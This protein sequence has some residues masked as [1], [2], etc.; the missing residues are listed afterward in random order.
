VSD[1]FIQQAVVTRRYLRVKKLLT[2][3]GRCVMLC[4]CSVDGTQH[5]APAERQGRT[6]ALPRSLPAGKRRPPR[7]TVAGDS[8]P[9]DI[10][11]F[12]LLNSKAPQMLNFPS[13]SRHNCFSQVIE[14]AEFFGYSL[15][16]SDFGSY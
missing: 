4:H 2:R 11:D 16:F 13:G 9:L 5:A 6:A 3:I 14:K 7:T 10:K 12:A 8:L 1:G 15:V